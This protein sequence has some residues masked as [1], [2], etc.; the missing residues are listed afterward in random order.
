MELIIK[1]VCKKIGDNNILTNVNLNIKKGDTFALVGPNG[2]GKTTLIRI[3]LGL[4]EMTKGEVYVDGVSITSKEYNQKKN[5]ISFVLD[6]LGL[7]RDL[8]AWEN[9]EFFDRIYNPKSTKND[10]KARIEKILKE[11]DLFNKSKDN[12]SF[13]SRGMKQRLAIGRTLVNTPKLFILDEPSKGL[14]VE[15]QVFLVDYIKRL[16][17]TGCTIFINSH[18][19]S[20][21]EKV[22]D[23][24]AF[25]KNG[26]IIAF[27]KYENLSKKLSLNMY[28]LK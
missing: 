14:D 1:N 28:S 2:A 19:L 5:E 11:I 16:K 15:G 13:F 7:F 27:D 22:C 4:Y 17:K 10:R 8:N 6:N 24:V 20:Y 21:I 23:C 18:D 9:I 12:I 25:I 3:I 26:E